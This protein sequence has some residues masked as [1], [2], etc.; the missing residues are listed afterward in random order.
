MKFKIGDRIRYCYKESKNNGRLG[1]VIGVADSV[2]FP[3][4]VSLDQTDIETTA[5][6]WTS[7]DVLEPHVETFRERLKREHPES[8]DDAFVGGCALCP[9]DYGYEPEP[10][11]CIDGDRLYCYQCWNRPI[12]KQTEPDPPEPVK[13]SETKTEEKPKKKVYAIF[14]EQFFFGNHYDRYLRFVETEDIF[15]EVGVLIYKASTA[16]KNIR[17]CEMP[18]ESVEAAIERHLDEYGEDWKRIDGTDVLR[19]IEKE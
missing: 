1:V 19:F 15:H 11:Y 4:Y 13:P 3:Y 7:E 8:V 2:Q 16:I 17:W 9:C 18:D 14:Y 10:E 5:V 6:F 12:S